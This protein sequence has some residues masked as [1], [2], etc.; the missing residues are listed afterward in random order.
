MKITFTTLLL[1]GLTLSSNAQEKEFLIGKWRFEDFVEK[2]EMDSVG[3]MLKE[4]IF[5]EETFYFKTNQRYQNVNETGNWRLNENE[6][7]IVFT[8]DDGYEY[9]NRLLK[10]SKDTLII[11]MGMGKEGIVFSRTPLTEEDDF[12]E[13]PIKLQT[14]SASIEEISQKWYLQKKDVPT[15]KNQRLSILS[16]TP[17]LSYQIKGSY[18]Q[19]SKNGKYKARFDKNRIKINSMWKFG[20]GNKSIIVPFVGSWKAIWNIHKISETEL[21]LIKGNSQKWYF[22]TKK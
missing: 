6:S 12:E 7:E 9:S 19:L 14:M 10:L 13:V 3:L 1:L 18:I 21:I 11:E 8:S 17:M 16:T 5:K 2:Q 22:S 15:S 4:M 20:E